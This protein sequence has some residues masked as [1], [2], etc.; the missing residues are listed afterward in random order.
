MKQSQVKVAEI[1]LTKPTMN[2]TKLNSYEQLV[3]QKDSLFQDYSE[4]KLQSLYDSMNKNAPNSKVAEFK[5]LSKSDKAK[6]LVNDL[7][8]SMTLTQEYEREGST[9]SNVLA[10]FNKRDNIGSSTGKKQCWIYPTFNVAEN[11]SVGGNLEVENHTVFIQQLT[12]FDPEVDKN[13]NVTSALK[14]AG[15]GGDGL[16][17]DGKPLFLKTELVVTTSQ[18]FEELEEQEKENREEM[19]HT[20]VIDAQLIPDD[21]KNGT[22]NFNKEYQNFIN[23]LLGKD[24]L[25]T[26]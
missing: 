13:G 4:E 20:E 1:S 12:T 23:S 7:T 26:V 24:H 3:N 17:K 22:A 19:K 25:V 5:A 9:T 14:R 6:K 16:M 11:F 18:S 21:S 2:I 15:K 10:M 8:V